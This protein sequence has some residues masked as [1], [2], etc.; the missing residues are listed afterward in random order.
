MRG[1]RSLYLSSRA[2]R[3]SGATRTHVI[4]QHRGDAA[5]VPALAALGRDDRANARTRVW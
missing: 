2:G 5:W 1:A 4:H 3:V